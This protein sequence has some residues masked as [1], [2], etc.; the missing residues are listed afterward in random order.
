MPA[1]QIGETPLQRLKR[2]RAEIAGER[3]SRR[4]PYQRSLDAQ[5]RER[6]ARRRREGFSVIRGGLDD[7]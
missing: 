7:A 1:E 5:R 6:A 4:T 3:E 2:I